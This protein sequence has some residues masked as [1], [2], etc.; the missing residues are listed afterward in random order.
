M[1]EDLAGLLPTSI[2]DTLSTVLLRKNADAQDRL[3]W[4]F[5]LNVIFSVKSA[6]SLSLQGIED[7]PLGFCKEI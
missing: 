2:E 7:P 5:T 4:N 6:Y 1:W 3:C